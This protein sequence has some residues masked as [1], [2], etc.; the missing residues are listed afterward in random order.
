MQTYHWKMW[1]EF[2]RLFWNKREL[3]YKTANLFEY[4]N[5]VLYYQN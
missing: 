2:A 3:I 4:E 1:I 5:A